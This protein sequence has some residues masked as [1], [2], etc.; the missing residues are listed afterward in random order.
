[1]QWIV[2]LVCLLAAFGLLYYFF[3]KTGFDELKGHE[4]MIIRDLSD[5]LPVNSP[6]RSAF[7]EA[8]QA[9]A[10]GNNHAVCR[11]LEKSVR[12][13]IRTRD[14]KSDRVLGLYFKAVRKIQKD[15]PGSSKASGLLQELIRQD[16]DNPNWL[17]FDFD[18]NPRIRRVLDYE[19]VRKK[20]IS[21]DG[22]IYLKRYPYDIN[23]ALER[24]ARLRRT[25]GSPK[26]TKA[27]M[28]AKR[29]FFDLCTV[30]LLLSS[31][32]LKG[33][34]DGKSVLPDNR[35]D[36]GVSEREKALRIAREHRDSSC[37]D[38]WNARLFIAET[39]CEHD[40][41][42]LNKF[43][44]N[45]IYW[46]GAYRKSLDELKQE[47]RDCRERLNGGQQL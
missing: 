10:K 22:L 7:N 19:E 6:Y 29:E 21:P 20:V 25:T 36:P 11:I 34:S 14:R 26:Y 12:E 3:P 37:R 33:Y 17:E 9:Y 27:E 43:K 2:S 24:L 18:L 16:P 31:W 15:R 46:N 32:L 8:C 28:A 4:G 13:I 44:L 23:Y 47:I 35:D 38:F 30:K 40:G 42:G 45:E 39:L 1:M 5:P 41:F